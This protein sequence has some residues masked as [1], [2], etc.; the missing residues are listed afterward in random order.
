MSETLVLG[1]PDKYYLSIVEVIEDWF[2]YIGVIETNKIVHS[3]EFDDIKSNPLQDFT[4]F[5]AKDVIIVSIDVY[6]IYYVGDYKVE[7][8]YPTETI[9]EHTD[10]KELV[11][12]GQK[13]LDAYLYDDISEEVNEGE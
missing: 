4:G 11:E 8:Q 10:N 12:R 7:A 5:G 2:G 3:Y 1:K 6:P 13:E 9:S